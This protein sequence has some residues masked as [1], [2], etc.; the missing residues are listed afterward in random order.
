[1]PTIHSQNSKH[2]QNAQLLEALHKYTLL[3]EQCLKLELRN[4]EY[5]LYHFLNTKKINSEDS[6][7]LFALLKPIHGLLTKLINQKKIKIEKEVIRHKLKYKIH[8]KPQ[9]GAQQASFLNNQLPLP[10]IGEIKITGL[11]E[12]LLS[13]KKVESSDRSIFPYTL[14]KGIQWQNII[15]KFLNDEDVETIV[16]RITYHTNFKEMGMVGKGKKPTPSVQWI[17]LK[18][19]AMNNGE[20]T[21]KDSDAR[22]LYKKQKQLLSESLK[23]FFKIDYDPFYPYHSSTEK[24]GNSYKIKMTLIPPPQQAYIVPLEKTISDKLGL[25]EYLKEEAPFI[26]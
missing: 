1:M 18:V 16:N 20:I 24:E 4:I 25:D 15:I 10:I 6:R 11:N 14:P 5:L 21:I 8:P 3:P 17:F 23:Q 2:R 19:L 22:P 9:L 13:L 26:A 7:L 12:T